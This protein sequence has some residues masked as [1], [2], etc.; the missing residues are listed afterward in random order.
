MGQQHRKNKLRDMILIVLEY[1]PS[2]ICSKHYSHT[3]SFF[4]LIF[5]HY[6]KEEIFDTDEEPWA[7]IYKL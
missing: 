3:T 6:F 2:L 1:R 4:C 5:I 7:S